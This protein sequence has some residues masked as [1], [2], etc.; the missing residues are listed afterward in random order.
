MLQ[1][2]AFPFLLDLTA[3]DLCA[4]F[5]AAP[6]FA[7]SVVLIQNSLTASREPNHQPATC[8]IRTQA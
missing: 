7:R 1:M 4:Q 6:D 2:L 3:T 8:V 5:A